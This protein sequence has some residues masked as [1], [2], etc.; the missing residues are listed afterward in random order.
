MTGDGFEQVALA[1]LIVLAPIALIVV[2][3]L[4]RGYTIDVHFTRKRK[5]TNDE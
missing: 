3:A 4:L 5:D 2:V 1:G